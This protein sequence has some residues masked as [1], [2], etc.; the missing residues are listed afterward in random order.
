MGG[1]VA[2]YDD[3]RHGTRSDFQ[4]DR[5]SGQRAVCASPPAVSI[6]RSLQSGAAM[7]SQ[8]L[9]KWMASGCLDYIERLLTDPFTLR[10]LAMIVEYV[11]QEKTIRRHLAP[12]QGGSRGLVEWSIYF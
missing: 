11:S 2:A 10:A 7:N 1:N 12:C 8:D 6:Y 5:P 9:V 3:A 4:G